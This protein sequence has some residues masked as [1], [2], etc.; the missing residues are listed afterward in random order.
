M[1]NPHTGSYWATSLLFSLVQELTAFWDASRK[2]LDVSTAGERVEA[3]NAFVRRIEEL[4]LPAA[5]DAKPF[6]DGNEVVRVLNAGRPGAWM[7]GALAR[8]VEWQ[9]RH[10]EGTKAQCE[11]WLRGEHTAGR[12]SFDAAPAKRVQNDAGVKQKKSKK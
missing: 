7:T 1:H 9:L 3:Y 8:V 10:P 12:I 11:E 2:S 5:V 6:L 4:N